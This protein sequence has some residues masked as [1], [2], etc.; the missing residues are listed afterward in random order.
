MDSI[1]EFVKNPNYEK[2]A[3]VDCCSYGLILKLL[4]LG[5]TCVVEAFWCFPCMFIFWDVANTTKTLPKFQCE[6]SSLWQE[7]KTSASSSLTSLSP[8]LIRLS[9][10][11]S[12]LYL[13]PISEV[14]CYTFQTRVSTLFAHGL[15][16]FSPFYIY[17]DV[18]PFHLRGCALPILN[19]YW[20]LMKNLGSILGLP[21]RLASKA[22]FLLHLM[23]GRNGWRV[24]VRHLSHYGRLWE[25]M[26]LYLWRFNL[27]LFGKSFCIGLCSFGLIDPIP[28]SSRMVRCP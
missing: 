27:C 28:S 1:D 11:D 3:S 22:G 9:K 8:T 19:P 15:I 12:S 7:K 2:L 13:H 21:N 6:I 4:L 14:E 23:G 24:F 17:M 5:W 16:C 10:G 25:L 26:T 20:L 18:I